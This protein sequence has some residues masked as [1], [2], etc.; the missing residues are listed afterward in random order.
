M[1]DPLRKL[2]LL[3]LLLPTNVKYQIAKPFRRFQTAFNY[4][5]SMLLQTI[6]K[7]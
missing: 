3:L 6:K 2:L 4:L 5:V 1:D 7:T